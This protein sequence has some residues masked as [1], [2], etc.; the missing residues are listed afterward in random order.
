MYYKV[1]IEDPIM[2]SIWKKNLS[3][4]RLC[5]G[6]WFYFFILMRK[7]IFIFIFVND[8]ISME[9]KLNTSLSI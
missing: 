9:N 5:L 1:Y 2:I 6:K 3:K 7:Y 8:S 4:K